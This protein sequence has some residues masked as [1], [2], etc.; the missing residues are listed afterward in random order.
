MGLVL[1]AI[2]AFVYGCA[3]YCGGKATRTAPATAVTFLSQTVGLLVLAVG[4]VLVPGDG[5]SVRAVGFGALG[6]LFGASGILFLYHGLSAG[7]MSIVSPVAAVISAAL[8]VLVAM[9]FFG[10]RPSVFALVGIISALIAIALVSSSPGGPSGERSTSASILTAVGAGVSFGLFFV[11]LQ[12]AGAPSEVGLWALVGARP[13]SIAVAGLL[14]RFRGDSLRVPAK[15]RPTALVAGLLDQLANVLYVLAI[16]RNLF[17]L[18][19]V[20]ASMFPVSTV[21]LAHFV[22]HE[23][24]SRPQRVGL[25]FA[26]VSLVLIAIPAEST[27]DSQTNQIHSIERAVH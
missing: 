12:R 14:A 23:R 6:G 27:K 16:G 19:A 21:A 24:V 2:S 20:L 10:E 22:D 9:I 11:C 26:L 7:K 15:A 8:P 17:A 5:P 25:L 13:V 3:D 4:V 18:I 1:A